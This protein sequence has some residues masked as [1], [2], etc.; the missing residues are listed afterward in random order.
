VDYVEVAGESLRAF[1][2]KLSP[3]VRAKAPARWVEAYPGAPWQ[4]IDRENYMLFIAG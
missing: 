1:E 4:K 3:K 2:F